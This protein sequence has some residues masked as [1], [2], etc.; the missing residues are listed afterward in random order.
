[1]FE[2]KPVV[3]IILTALLFYSLFSLA[4]AREELGRLKVTAEELREEYAELVSVNAKLKAALENSGT[5]EDME[6]LAR[7]KLGLVYPGEKVFY[8]T[9]TDRED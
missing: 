8:F 6:R 7:E 2:R 5:P 9:H 3:L 1:M 4:S